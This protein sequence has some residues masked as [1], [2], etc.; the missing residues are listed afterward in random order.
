MRVTF[1]FTDRPDGII[2]IEADAPDQQFAHALNDAV[3]SRAPRGAVHQGL[4][5]YWID[6]TEAAARQAAA[7][8]Q[9]APFA[10]GNVAYLR[11]QGNDVIAGYDFDEDQGVVSSMPGEDFLTLL[12]DWR[13]RVIAA[14]GTS[15]IAAALLEEQ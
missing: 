8:G 1:R 2:E 13:E 7:S 6:R 12:N 14:G 4:S 9:T 3:S 15:G 5:T 11:L 10:S